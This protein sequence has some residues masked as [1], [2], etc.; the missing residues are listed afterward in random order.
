[1]IKG[2]RINNG[3]KT[4][5]LDSYT[6]KNEIRTFSHTLYK[7]KLKMD[8]KPDCKTGNHKNIEETIG[9]MNVL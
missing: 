9:R 7:N 4:G 6:Q 2:A 3:L 1:M 8:Y 5:K